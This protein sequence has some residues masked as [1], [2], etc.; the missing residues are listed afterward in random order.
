MNKYFF[1]ILGCILLASCGPSL[2]DTANT[3]AAVSQL[4]TSAVSTVYAQMTANGPTATPRPT[5]TPRP[6][7][8][9]YPSPTP[10]AF[11]NPAPIGSTITLWDYSHALSKYSL[12]LID[13]QRDEAAKQLAQQFLSWYYYDEP[14]EGQE[15]IAIYVRMDYLETTRPNEVDNINPQLHL[16]LRYSLTDT[17]TVFSQDFVQH[18]A[19]GYVPLS[20]E[21]WVFYLVRK[22]TQ[23][24]LYFMPWNAMEETYNQGAFF[25]LS[26][27]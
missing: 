5:Y 2:E 17:T 13:V 10:G 18:L 24:F 12:T 9:P 14:I 19:E 7:S 20:G 21:G 26:K 22:D 27:P 8:T 6:T 4:Q 16:T 15:Y 11:S 23:P 1:L 3:Q 25:N